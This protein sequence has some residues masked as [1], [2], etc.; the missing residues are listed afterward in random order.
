VEREGPV[1]LGRAT[2]LLFTREGKTCDTGIE[3]SS[4]E[5]EGV[6]DGGVKPTDTTEAESDDHLFG[7]WLLDDSVSDVLNEAGTDTDVGTPEV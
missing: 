3:G 2:G 6:T 4:V 7:S 5:T 1:E